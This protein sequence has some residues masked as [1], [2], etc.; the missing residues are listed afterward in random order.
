MIND[1]NYIRQSLLKVRAATH[2]PLMNDGAEDLSETVK[3]DDEV[4]EQRKGT[5]TS[6]LIFDVVRSY[7]SM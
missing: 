6:F 1:Y 3:L 4:V 7:N 2:A 5:C